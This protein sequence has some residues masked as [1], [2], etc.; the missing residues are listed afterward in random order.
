MTSSAVFPLLVSNVRLTLSSSAWWYV[1]AA[2]VLLAVAYAVYRYT[3]PPVS[4]IRR[5]I[6]WLLR[7]TALVLLTLLLF[8]PVLSY[9]FS[10][11]QPPAVALLVDVSASISG[12]SGTADRAAV[13]K[14]WLTS[15]GTRQL[16]DKS[17]LRIFTF[18]DSTREVPSDSLN[19]LAFSSVGTDIA[20]AIERAEKSL[21]GEN[22]AAVV[23]V[24]D[25]AYNSGENPVRVAAESPAPIYTIGVGDTAASRDAVI[26]QML[27]NEITYVGSAVP[28]ELRVRARGLKG[29]QATLRLAGPGGKEYGRQIVHFD[30]EDTEQSVSLT[31]ATD[32]PGDIRVVAALDS[33]PGESLLDNNRR[34]VIIRVLE[35]KSKVLLFSGPPTPDLTILRQTLEDDSTLQVELFAESMGTDLLYH[36][37]APTED[38]L[39]RADLIVLMNYPSR[40]TSDGTLQRIAQSVSERDIPV[41][42]FA[43]PQIAAGKL[44][45]LA[46][47][48]PF[49]PAKQVLSE[50]RILL[51]SVA[52]HSVLS[53][54]TPL[55]R[56]WAD[57]PPTT[58]GLDNFDVKAGAQVVVKLSRESLGLTEDEP[59]VALWQMGR[60]HGAAFFCWGLYRWR[61]DNTS[62]ASASFYN[63]LISRL[64]AWLIAPAEE[65]RVKV[66]TTKRLYSGGEKVQFV[67]Q[68][69]GSDL[70][71]RD[72]ATINLRVTSGS[73]S[74]VVAMR[75]RGSGRYGGELPPWAEGEY[76]FVA[77]AFVESDTL[78]TD[79]GLFA[80]EAFNIE[81]VDTRAR[82][83][84]LQAVSMVSH[85]RFVPL[86]KA[87][88]LVSALQFT[89][90]AMTAHREIPLWNRALLVWIIIGLLA[91][92]WI[93]RKR[94]GM[95]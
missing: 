31:F 37:K 11:K 49:T 21:A 76:N 51:R 38:D 17:Q 23:V 71:P 16:A 75:S 90:R 78:G 3:L 19:G 53:A 91:A 44:Q 95:L 4:G 47:G 58:G 92:E 8:E 81:L 73:R 36:E 34:S 84:V 33:V 6:L 69:Y 56:E 13:V 30:A 62:A 64:V 26:S 89:P 2:L 32:H 66:R 39:S 50:E 88:S 52:A 10:R 72:D 28:I 20:G 61:M 59:A 82:F 35:N 9:I 86:A 48:L 83:D 40:N 65:Q 45:T 18:S 60:K 77:S 15:S 22:L 7:G 43:G 1:L 41:L 87:D 67:G 5:S 57:L 14:H 63:Q 94:S 68:V 46:G 55:P 12:S 54:E 74:E 29:Q 24:T 93:L 25:G 79:R 80:V 85:G 27:T 70:A 42:F